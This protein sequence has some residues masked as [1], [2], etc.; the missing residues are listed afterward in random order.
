MST[1]RLIKRPNSNVSLV[2]VGVD[3]VILT[4]ASLIVVI[5]SAHGICN[6]GHRNRISVVIYNLLVLIPRF[7]SILHRHDIAFQDSQSLRTVK[8]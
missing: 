5:L 6:T 3:N 4:V 1:T 8:I 7:T 2:L